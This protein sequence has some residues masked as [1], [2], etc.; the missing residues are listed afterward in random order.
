MTSDIIHVQAVRL[1]LEH[2]AGAHVN[3]SDEDGFTPLLISV[4]EKDCL[5][6]AEV[7]KENGTNPDT[8]PDTDPDPNPARRSCWSM[9][10]MRGMEHATG[11]DSLVQN[12]ESSK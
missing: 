4:T 6:V 5:E 10:L 3:V 1:L 7:L 2:G 12:P 8:D 9:G 11:G